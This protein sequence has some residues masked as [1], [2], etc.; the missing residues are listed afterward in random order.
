MHPGSSRSQRNALQI[1]LEKFCQSIRGVKVMVKYPTSRAKVQLDQ[2]GNHIS[3]GN[4]GTSSWAQR[5]VA[6]RQALADAFD[7]AA[8]DRDKAYLPAV[9][10]FCAKHFCLA[11]A[12][13]ISS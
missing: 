8:E 12:R 5:S 11:A 1:D 6:L 4:W 3:L 13:P 9:C 7:Q 2:L 10:K